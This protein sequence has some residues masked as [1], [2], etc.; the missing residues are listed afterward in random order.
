MKRTKEQAVRTPSKEDLGEIS[1]DEAT[2]KDFT[3]QMQQLREQLYKR[4][5]KLELNQQD[6][7]QILEAKLKKSVKENFEK[8]NKRIK[9]SDDT[10]SKLQA[11]LSKFQTTVNQMK[12]N[13]TN[14]AEFVQ[15]GNSMQPVAL[16]KC[17]E[18]VAPTVHSER[19]SPDHPHSK[20]TSEDDNYMELYVEKE[21]K[22]KINPIEEQLKQRKEEIEKIVER[23]STMDDQMRKIDKHYNGVA[24]AI[25]SKQGVVLEEIGEYHILKEY[26]RMTDKEA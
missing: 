21:L 14:G 4:M 15:P 6:N 24:R 3:F 25:L 9:S 1:M 5:E 20:S 12:E 16:I 10:I 23:L 8:A 13:L 2:A 7:R 18:I 19:S 26:A 11:N 17:E 22:D